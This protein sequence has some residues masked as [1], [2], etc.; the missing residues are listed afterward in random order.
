MGWELYNP[1]ARLDVVL[2]GEIPVGD[3]WWKVLS[4]RVDPTTGALTLDMATVDRLGNSAEDVESVYGDSIQVP[5]LPDPMRPTPTWGPPASAAAG[6][7]LAE[8]ARDLRVFHMPDASGTS[9]AW[10]GWAVPYPC[11]HI[12]LAERLEQSL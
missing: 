10:C 1:L 3:G 5:D 8:V 7:V 12:R 9:C 2:I 6:T 4:A 11:D